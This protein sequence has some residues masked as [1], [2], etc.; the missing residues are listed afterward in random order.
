VVR[1]ESTGVQAGVLIPLKSFH[2]AKARL[3]ALL[4]RRERSALAAQMAWGVVQAAAPLPTFVICDDDDVADWASELGVEALVREAPGLSAAVQSGVA[5]MTARGI[6]HLI[7]AH[8]DLPLAAAAPGG[9]ARWVVPGEVR[10]ITDARRDGTN[11]VSLPAG[12][13]WRFAYGPG[14]CERHVAEAER[15]GLTIEIVEDPVF[16]LDLDL[17]DDVAHVWSV[18]RGDAEL[19]EHCRDLMALLPSSE[20]SS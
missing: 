19:A 2:H 15:L 12:L 8:G 14:S 4:S 3:S 6:D 13:G 18:L 16:S 11:V 1:S 17:P 5:E 20:E 10:V 7:V 9:L